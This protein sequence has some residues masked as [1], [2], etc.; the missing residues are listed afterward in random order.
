M[1]GP[2]IARSGQTHGESIDSVKTFF[3]FFALSEKI[4]KIFFSDIL[5]KFQ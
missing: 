3:F 5:L 4:R 1:E 2:K